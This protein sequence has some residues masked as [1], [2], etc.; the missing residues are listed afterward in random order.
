MM[1]R[2]LILAGGF[3]IG[4]IVGSLARKFI[5]DTDRDE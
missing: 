3:L 1:E 5:E 4:M 2:F